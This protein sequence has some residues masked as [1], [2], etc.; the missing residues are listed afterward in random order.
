MHWL[1]EGAAMFEL[2]VI[3]NAKFQWAKFAQNL[4]L[5]YGLTNNLFSAAPMWTD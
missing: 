3:K 1:S 5:N 4:Y 2:L